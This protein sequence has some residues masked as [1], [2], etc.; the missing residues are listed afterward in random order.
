MGLW[1]CPH[2]IWPRGFISLCLLPGTLSFLSF[3]LE[4]AS[5]QRM[6]AVTYRLNL[7]TKWVRFNPESR[8]ELLK[9]EG[10]VATALEREEAAENSATEERLEKHYLRGLQEI[11]RLA[12]TVLETEA[13]PERRAL[14]G[15]LLE[16]VAAVNNSQRSPVGSRSG[17]AMSRRQ[18][19]QLIQNRT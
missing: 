2:A 15:G 1:Y 6:A 7:R 17:A 3:S 8:E 5:P 10:E 19:L 12:Q 14:V 4:A 18:I 9:L 13:R 11:K 16:T